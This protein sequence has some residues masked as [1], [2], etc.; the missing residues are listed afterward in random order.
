MDDAHVL[1]AEIDLI[2]NTSKSRKEYIDDFIELINS[3]KI[4]KIEIVWEEF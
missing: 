3:D 1:A 4:P 2:K